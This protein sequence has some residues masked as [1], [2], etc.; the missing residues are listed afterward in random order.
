MQLLRLLI[1]VGCLKKVLRC[2]DHNG[3]N[4]IFDRH[5]LPFER[6]SLLDFLLDGSQLLIVEIAFFFDLLDFLKE[7]FVIKKALSQLTLQRV[8]Q[9]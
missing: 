7:H 8:D 4:L 6:F 3:H 5:M 9:V 2:A 1:W